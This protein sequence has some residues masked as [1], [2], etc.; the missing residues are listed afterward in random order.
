MAHW[1]WAV[2][3]CGLGTEK[4]LLPKNIPRPFP[5]LEGLLRWFEAL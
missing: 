2:L 5:A 3:E 1:G 4:G